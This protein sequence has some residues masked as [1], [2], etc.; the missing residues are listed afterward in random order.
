M[1]KISFYA[2]YSDTDEWMTTKTPMLQGKIF[3]HA[4]T[5]TEAIQI[6]RERVSSFGWDDINIYAATYDLKRGDRPCQ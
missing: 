5:I 6:A 4:D 1:W 2:N 3:I